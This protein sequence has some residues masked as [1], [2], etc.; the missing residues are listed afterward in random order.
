M[1][2]QLRLM[3]ETIMVPDQDSTILTFQATWAPLQMEMG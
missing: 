2:I 3:S 1:L